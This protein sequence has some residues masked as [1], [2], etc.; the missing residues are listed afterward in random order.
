MAVSIII[1]KMTDLEVTTQQEPDG[2]MTI[3]LKGAI[4]AYSYNKLENALDNL[5]EQETYKL[6]VDLSQVDYMASHGVGLLIGMLGLVQK[7]SGNI[8]L[9]D[10]K[11]AVR[12][13][14]ELLGL[15]HLFTIAEN[16]DIAFKS[17]QKKAY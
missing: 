6:I 8:V 17:F 4:D 1:D 16:K 13:V 11:P 3:A 15:N 7:N 12:D 2:V 9:L 14:L 10:P 5:I